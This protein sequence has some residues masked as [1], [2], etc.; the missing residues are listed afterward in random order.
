MVLIGDNA[1]MGATTRPARPEDLASIGSIWQDF[2]VHLRTVNEDYWEVSDDGS[3]FVG[4]LRPMLNVGHVRVAVAEDSAA[5][6]VGFGL[7]MTETL[8]EW[9][10]SRRLGLIRYV[11]V[12]PEARN[13]GFGQ[14]LVEH[15]LD[16]YRELG[17]DRVELYVLAGLQAERFW[18]RQGFKP[19]MDRRFIEL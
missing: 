7:G 13:Q 9:F 15:L 6:V 17:I 19:F 3:S 1:A 8:P 16:W 11:A 14:A 10:G 5:S 18:S 2:M 12:S 4:W